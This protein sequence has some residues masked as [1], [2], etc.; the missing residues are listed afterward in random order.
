VRSYP[1]CRNSSV[2]FAKPK[3][4]SDA[5]SVNGFAAS[6][7]RRGIEVWVRAANAYAPS[8]SQNRT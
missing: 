1:G 3:T 8:P 5:L 4:L 6:R 2:D 7:S